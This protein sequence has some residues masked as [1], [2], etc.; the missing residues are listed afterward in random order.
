MSRWLYLSF[1]IDATT[2]AYGGGGSFSAIAVKS[3]ARG[4]ACNG[5]AWTL[6]NHL[7][8]HLD[9]PRHFVLDGK[10]WADYPP[11]FW[12]FRKVCLL[13]IS[14]VAPGAWITPDGLNADAISRDSELVL[15]KTG[16]SALRHTPAYGR[17]GP[18]FT[19]GLAA[20][21]RERCPRL[22]VLGFD[23]ISLSS[24][25]ERA[26][27]REAHQAFLDHARPLLLLEDMDLTGVTPTTAFLQVVAAPL[28]VVDAD[29][30]PCAVLAEV[31]A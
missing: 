19:P 11:E 2:P 7:G 6:P 27:G 8:T 10:T 16:F 23:T 31:A 30:A 1:P 29:A 26:L 28:P 9:F 24:W 3:L 15:I 22:R 20:M 18:A 14:P 13:D 4:D 5:A 25:T 21:L 12:I 17:A